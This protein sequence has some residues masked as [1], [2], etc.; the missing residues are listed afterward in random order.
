[1]KR[2]ENIQEIEEIMDEEEWSE[3]YKTDLNVF[4]AK[5]PEA[6]VI[7][8]KIKEDLLPPLYSLMHNNRSYHYMEFRVM[9]N[10]LWCGIFNQG[11]GNL[12]TQ[13]DKAKFRIKIASVDLLDD[14]VLNLLLQ[15][16]IV[17]LMRDKLII[18]TGYSSEAEYD[19]KRLIKIVSRN[20]S[21][22]N[23]RL[24]PPYYDNN[25][26]LEKQ[27]GFSIGTHD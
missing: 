3:G 1:M 17:K 15:Y 20:D 14:E 7:W 25:F 18:I 10:E 21:I 22:F 26:Q 19:A 23:L 24:R 2:V 4:L 9:N 13:P 5:Y 16:L 12:H 11:D 27:M 8:R 6:A